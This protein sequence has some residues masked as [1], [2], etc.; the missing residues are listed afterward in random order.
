MINYIRKLRA[1]PVVRMIAPLLND[2]SNWHSS[3][4]K[5]R[6]YFEDSSDVIQLSKDFPD[7]KGLSLSH[8]GYIGH[9]GFKIVELQFL[10]GPM[11]TYSD[12]RLRFTVSEQNWLTSLFLDARY[13]LNDARI[14]ERD[15]AQA[16][17][18]KKMASSLKQVKKGKQ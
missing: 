10:E 1:R 9:S 13:K 5:F 2:Y 8:D 3:S 11:V 18:A 12:E 15:V 16:A 7:I 4:G 17:L 6:Y 14:R